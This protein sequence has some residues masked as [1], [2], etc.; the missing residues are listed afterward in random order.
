MSDT[1]NDPN[2]NDPNKGALAPTAGE[3]VERARPPPSKS[4]GPR[5]RRTARWKGGRA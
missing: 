3:A 2:K 1:M 4:V 5:E